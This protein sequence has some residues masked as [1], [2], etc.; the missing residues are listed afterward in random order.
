MLFQIQFT[1][2]PCDVQQTPSVVQLLQPAFDLGHSCR[3][4][5]HMRQKIG[6]SNCTN[7]IL[8]RFEQPF[9][10][11]WA[12]NLENH[13]IWFRSARPINFGHTWGL[14][15]SIRAS[16]SS[17]LADRLGSLWPYPRWMEWV[18][19]RASLKLSFVRCKL[20]LCCNKIQISTFISIGNAEGA[21]KSWKF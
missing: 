2:L 19:D 11:D 18:T 4:E 7:K 8:Y 5:W 10:N 15:S 6:N 1:T 3:G 21:K 20:P 14:P 12:W 9:C 16:T 13:R 17:P